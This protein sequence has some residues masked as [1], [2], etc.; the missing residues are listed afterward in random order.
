MLEVVD[1]DIGNPYTIF[2]D[3]FFFFYKVVSIFVSL[4]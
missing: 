3:V 1:D 4:S 2:P